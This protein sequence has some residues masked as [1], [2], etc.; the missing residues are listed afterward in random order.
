MRRQQGGAAHRSP[1]EAKTLVSLAGGKR[2]ALTS[3]QLLVEALEAG[4]EMA[5]ARRGGVAVPRRR[6]GRIGGCVQT[7]WG[8]RRQGGEAGGGGTQVLARARRQRRCVR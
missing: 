2:R 8:C 5:E 1:C 6:G 3:V 7:R 4:E